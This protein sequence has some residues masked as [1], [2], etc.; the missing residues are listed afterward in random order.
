MPSNEIHLIMIEAH[1]LERILKKAQRRRR[2]GTI[3]FITGSWMM[4]MSVFAR[5]RKDD[6]TWDSATRRQ[7]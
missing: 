5:R 3:M 2:A 4:V 7:P 6:T 1:K